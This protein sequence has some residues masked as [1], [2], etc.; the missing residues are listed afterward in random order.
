MP[1]PVTAKRLIATRGVRARY[2]DRS[3]RTLKRWIRAGRFPPPD[4]IINNRHFWWLE[5]LERHE[6]ELVAG[7]SSSSAVV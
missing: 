6:R 7:K 2:A 4:V 5:T 1:S 3:A